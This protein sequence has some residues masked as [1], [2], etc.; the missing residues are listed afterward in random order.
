ME[1]KLKDKW[2]ALSPSARR[3]LLVNYLGPNNR[4]R[5]DG[6]TFAARAKA[7]KAL[8][9]EAGEIGKNWPRP[10]QL[11]RMKDRAGWYYKYLTHAQ[12]LEYVAEHP[13]AADKLLVYAELGSDFATSDGYIAI[14]IEVCNGVGL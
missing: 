5:V 3:A 12:I 10:K 8:M 2:M 7:L 11:R 6:P 13:E 1:H 4:C 9:V 14:P